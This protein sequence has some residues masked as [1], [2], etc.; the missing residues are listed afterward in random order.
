MQLSWPPHRELV[1]TVA[2]EAHTVNPRRPGD[3]R[4][5]WQLV[6]APLGCETEPS[7]VGKRDIG[8]LPEQLHLL[9]R[10]VAEPLMR[11]SKGVEP[12]DPSRL[13]PRL[14]GTERQVDFQVRAVDRVAERVEKRGV[15]LEGSDLLRSRVL[16]RKRERDVVL[17]LLRRGVPR[18]VALLDDRHGEEG[19]QPAP[20]TVPAPPFLL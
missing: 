16:V 7:A 19:L 1:H 4:R 6:L 18:H 10:G 14:P 20:A 8:R 17:E 2:W 15:P 12:D 9:E 11:D 5:T 13:A 3:P